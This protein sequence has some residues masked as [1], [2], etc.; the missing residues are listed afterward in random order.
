MIN[1]LFPFTKSA[2]KSLVSLIVYVILF[3]GVG[4][5]AG[6]IG[7]LTGWLPL[8]GWL[9]NLLVWVI[10]VYCGLSIIVAIL[11]YFKVIK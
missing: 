9:F 6:F 10:R 2:K 1:K 8:L 11:A 3:A 4:A 5:V 7:K